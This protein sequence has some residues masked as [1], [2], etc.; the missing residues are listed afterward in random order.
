MIC[1]KCQVGFRPEK[2]GVFVA[3]MFEDNQKI[4]A[5]WHADLW[6]CPVCGIEVVAGFGNNPIK[7]HYQG[8]LESMI[9]KIKE[10]GGTVIYDRESAMRKREF[11]EHF[12]KEWRKF[13][14]YENQRA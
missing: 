14:H 10:K 9:A 5:V 11:N 2:N 4:Y 12:E 8:D 7:E 1:T 6:K 3:E 13:I